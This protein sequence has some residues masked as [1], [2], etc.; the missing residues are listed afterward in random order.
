M[1]VSEAKFTARIIVEI[2]QFSVFVNSF[3]E[4]LTRGTGGIV[5]YEAPTGPNM[6]EWSFLC[7]N[8]YRFYNNVS[9]YGMT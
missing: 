3:Y 7:H 5:L 2:I 8:Y 1:S 9:L 6:S 4:Q